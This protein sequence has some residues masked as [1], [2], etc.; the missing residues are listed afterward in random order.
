MRTVLTLALVLAALPVHGR[1]ERATSPG[2]ATVFIRLTGSARIEFDEADERRTV[3][4]DHVE[5]STGSGFLFSP[6]GYVLTNHH[7]VTNPEAF[8]LTRGS[9]R[10]KVTLAIERID[11]CFPPEVVSARG[12]ASGCASGSVVASD[13]ALDL[14]ALFIGG[15]DLPYIGL[16]DSDAATAGLQVDALGYPF[17]RDVEVGKGAS[18]RDVVPEVSM[19]PGAISALRADDAGQQRYLQV[20]NTLN[21]GN[22]GGPLVTRDGFAVGVIC[23]KL[24]EG[25]GI[26]FAIPVNRVKDF[27]ESSGLEAFAPVRRLRLGAFEHLEAKRLG[28]RLPEGLGDT[29]PFRSHLETA[30]QS[31]DVVLRIDRVLSPWPARRLEETLVGTQAF[32]TVLMAAREGRIAPRPGSPPLL[33]GAAVGDIPGTSEELRMDYGV[34]DLGAEKLI[35]RYVGPAE[36][37]AFNEGVLRESLRSLQAERMLAGGPVPTEQVEWSGVPG[38]PGRDIAPMP[39]GWVIE[40]GRPSA[41]AGI[42]QPVSTASASPLRDFTLVLRAAA[43]PDGSVDPASAAAA[44]SA[45]RGSLGDASYSTRDNW[46]G[47]AYVVEGVFLRV[48]AGQVVQLEVVS[49]VEQSARARDLLDAWV[50]KARE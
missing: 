32:E 49:T 15:S 12:M 33:L 48:G 11:V 16:G 28:I 40:P 45:R 13:A 43:W 1:T 9:L 24:K 4:L 47:V 14:A 36:A 38:L 30:A 6:A 21:P 25:T 27:L 8:I 35:A 46:L 23:M 37:M 50:K 44:C 20:T 2:D 26:G 29:S 22:S 17:G 10:A 42:R 31:S 18:A 19:T 41:C 3:E 7:V 5:I 34:L 39:A